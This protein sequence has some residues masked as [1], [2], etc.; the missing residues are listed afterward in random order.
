MRDH[1]TF[2]GTKVT[3][4]TQGQC[5]YYIYLSRPDQETEIWLLM[6][7]LSPLLWSSICLNKNFKCVKINF[8]LINKF[9]FGLD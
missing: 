6:Q 2:N 5:N 1:K 3:S 4:L 7:V 9:F 8:M